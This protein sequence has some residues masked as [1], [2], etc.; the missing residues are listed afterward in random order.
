MGNLNFNSNNND[1]N[2]KGNVNN[3]ISIRNNDGNFCLERFCY[4]ISAVLRRFDLKIIEYSNQMKYYYNN[5]NLYCIMYVCIYVSMLIFLFFFY[6]ISNKACN[7][8]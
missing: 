8:F 3:N 2:V 7:C 5:I 1:N 4:S 6:F